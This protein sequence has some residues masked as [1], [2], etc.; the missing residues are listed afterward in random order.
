MSKKYK[1]TTARQVGGDD[2][3]CWA[4]FVNG[5]MRLNGLTRREVA[6]WRSVFEQEQAAKGQPPKSFEQASGEMSREADRRRR[7]TLGNY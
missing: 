2:G 6:Y 1:Y 7:Q 4:V 5:I 3:Y